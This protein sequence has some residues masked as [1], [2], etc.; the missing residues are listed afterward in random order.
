MSD[1]HKTTADDAFTLAFQAACTECIAAA[2][3]L[4]PRIAAKDRS[5][6]HEFGRLAGVAMA[7]A[8]A[9]E[10]EGRH[11]MHRILA[12]VLAEAQA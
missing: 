9:T 3:R 12:A 10:D 2:R 5:A 4:R 1:Q 11:Y 7:K 6:M 8:G